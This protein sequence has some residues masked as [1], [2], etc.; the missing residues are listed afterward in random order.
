MSYR[1]V[2]PNWYFSVMAASGVN[3][4]EFYGGRMNAKYSLE[5]ND[6]HAF[7]RSHDGSET[8]KRLIGMTFL[9]NSW[10]LGYVGRIERIDL[11]DQ[12]DRAPRVSVWIK[13]GSTVHRL[14][15][16]RDGLVKNMFLLS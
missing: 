6:F 14:D 7:L 9:V 13:A 8:L 16:D 5:K 12:P 2:D 10:L 1:I 3:I 15:S 11:E 4:S